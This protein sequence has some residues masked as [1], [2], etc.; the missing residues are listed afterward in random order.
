MENIHVEAN[1]TLICQHGD[2]Y[3][4]QQQGPYTNHNG[5]KNVGKSKGL[6][7]GAILCT[8]YKSLYIFLSSLCKTNKYTMG[9]LF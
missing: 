6:M 2:F 7:S 3:R 8:C 1:R 4:P 5:S 9:A